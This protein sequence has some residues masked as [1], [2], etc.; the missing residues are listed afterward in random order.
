MPDEQEARLET[1]GHSGGFRVKMCVSPEMYGA[2]LTAWRK[3]Q[4]IGYVARQARV[5]PKIARRVITQ[6]VPELGLDPFPGAEIVEQQAKELAAKREARLQAQREPPD[7]ATRSTGRVKAA[8]GFKALKDAERIETEIR[9][10]IERYEEEARKLN[11]ELDALEATGVS[12]SAME[13]MRAAFGRVLVLDGAIKRIKREAIAADEMQ[14]SAEEAAASRL[15]MRTAAGIAAIVA[16]LT[17]KF[18]DDLEQ[19]RIKLPETLDHKTV[20][21]LARAADISAST[22]ERA[23]SIERKRLGQ[24]EQIVGVQLGMMLESCTDEELEH[25]MQNKQAPARLTSLV[26]GGGRASEDNG[27][28]IVEDAEIIESAEAQR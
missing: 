13:Q 19:G 17:E 10:R 28:A 18:L 23:L 20:L 22:V 9:G 24:P 7:P 11:K 15:T 14:K 26:V 21:L 16:T 25:I 2:M 6:G 3:C 12:R 27:A 1:F 4:T 5:A 8:L